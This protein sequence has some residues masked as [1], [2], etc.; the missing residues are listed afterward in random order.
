M[1]ISKLLA[2]DHTSSKDFIM[3]TKK[4][5]DDYTIDGDLH[6]VLINDEGQYSIWPAGQN[7]PY[8][9]KEVDFT[10]SKAECSAYVDANWLDMRPISL[11]KAMA[12][13]TY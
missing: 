12:Q 9:W 10:G 6:K 2:V 5:I 13:K 11:Q 4:R 1:I 3:S 8:G 7:A